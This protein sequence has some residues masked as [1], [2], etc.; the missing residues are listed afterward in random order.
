MSRVESLLQQC[1]VKLSLP[2]GWGTGFFVAPQWILTC[3]HVVKKAEREPVQ[4]RWQTQ[5]N[6]SQAVV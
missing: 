5:E 4:V 2:G 6:W 3:A 1:T